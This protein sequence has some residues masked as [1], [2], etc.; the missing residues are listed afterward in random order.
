MEDRSRSIML[1]GKEDIENE[2]ISETVSEIFEDLGEKPLIVEVR[3]IGTVKTG[4]C[5]PIKVKLSNPEAV[6]HVL[7]KSR[8]LKSS[9]KNRSTFLVADRSREEREAYKKLVDQMRE[10]IGQ[11]PKMY[12]FIKGGQIASVPRNSSHTTDN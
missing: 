3:R 6:A 1:F 4:K 5:R 12:H 7:R 2:D 10:K 8:V 9:V 11:E